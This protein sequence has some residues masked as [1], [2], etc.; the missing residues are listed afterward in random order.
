MGYG[1]IPCRL[2]LLLSKRSSTQW[3]R[4][5]SKKSA[6]T[7]AFAA[8]LKAKVK[9][10]PSDGKT[11]NIQQDILPKNPAEKKKARRKPKTV[12]PTD[13]ERELEGE[14]SESNRQGWSGE[15]WKEDWGED[16]TFFNYIPTCNR[17][18]SLRIK[19]ITYLR[20]PRRSSPHL[21]PDCIFST[22]RGT[23]GRRT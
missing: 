15:T 12:V 18:Y 23:T 3:A 16:S 21:F 22:H 4:G 19:R 5:Y 2:S 17:L 11:A 20:F 7:G 14:P 9:S 10:I 1:V 8:K 13:P 6:T